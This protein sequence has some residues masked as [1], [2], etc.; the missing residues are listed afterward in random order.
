M[1]AHHDRIG[2]VVAASVVILGAAGVAYGDMIGP[3]EFR[4][5]GMVF[6]SLGGMFLFWMPFTDSAKTYHLRFSSLLFGIS[7]LCLG[8]GLMLRENGAIPILREWSRNWM[9]LGAVFC[10]ASF[11]AV[12]RA[13]RRH[14]P[15]STETQSHPPGDHTR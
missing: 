4:F 2:I 7:C 3:R 10:F 12:R 1:Q 15:E 9:A 13:L 6:C 8:Y 14:F 11:V 5:L